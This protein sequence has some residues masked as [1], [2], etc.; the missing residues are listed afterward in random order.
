[1]P[2]KV[3][4]TSLLRDGASFSDAVKAMG[5]HVS[6]AKKHEMFPFMSLMEEAKRD[7]DPSLLD[8]KVAVTFSPKLTNKSC[9]LYPVEG[10]WDLFFCFLEQDDGVSLGVS[11]PSPPWQRYL[12][13]YTA[14]SLAT[15]LSSAGRR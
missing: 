15:R 9:T 8:F 1:M 10:I 6:S 12:L 13:T 7:T 2:V 3:P 14:R 4:L 11:G 5:H